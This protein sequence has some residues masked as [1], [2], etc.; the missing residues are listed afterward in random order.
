MIRILKGLCLSIALLSC[1][2]FAS[3]TPA[4]ETATIRGIVADPSGAVIPGATV[5][6]VSHNRVQRTKSGPEGR[7]SFSSLAPGTYSVTVAAKGF[8]PFTTP[9]V[10]LAAGAAKDLKVS[11]AIAVEQE[12]VTVDDHS[13]SVGL[14]PDQNS[15]AMVIKGSDLDALSDD[16]D[17]LQNELQ[18]LAGPAAGPSGGQIY[19]DGFEGGQIPPKSSILEIRVNQNPFSAEFDRIGYGRIEIITKPGTQKL[20]GNFGGFGTASPLNT[21]NP[22]V[23]QP[24]FYDFYSAMGNV[25]G[26]LSKKAAYF[27]NV[28]DMQRQTQSIVNA[29]NPNNPSTNIVEFFPTP[30]SIFEISPRIDFQLGIHNITIRDGFFRSVASNNGVG[31]LNLPSQ[32]VSS[33]DKENSVQIG[34]TVVINEHLVNETHFQWRR[35]RNDQTAVKFTPAVTVQGS[36]TK[37]GSSTGVVQDHEDNFE[38]QNYSTATA[39]KHILRFGTRLRAERDTNFSESGTNGAYSFSTL[40]AYQAQTPT[41]YSQTVV[42]NPIARA[43]LFDA[44]LFLQ[45]DWHP[46]KNLVAGLGL[47]YEGQN[48]IRDHAD[49]GPRV[50]FAWSP[51]YQGKGAAKT[52]VR[53]GYGWFYNRFTVP[54]SFQSSGTPYIIQTIHDNGINQKS[55]TVKAP[56]FFNP[57]APQTEQ[58]LQSLGTTVPTY[59]TVDPHFHAALDMQGGVGVDRQITKALTGNITYLFTQG[60]HQYLMDNVTAPD[61]DPSTYTVNGTTPAAYNYQFQSGGFYRQQEL[62]VTAKAHF[63][64]LSFDSNYTLNYANSDTQG[65]NSVPM[66][67]QHPGLD[68]GRASFGI[69]HRIFLLLTYTAPGG[70]I[71]APLLAA[72]SGTPYNI[73][74]GT[75]LTQ[76]NQFNARP[77]Y[78]ICGQ[79]GLVS[80]PFGCLDSNPVGKNEKIVP[81]NLGTGP[82]NFVLHLRASKTIGIGPHIKQE[83]D[84]AGQ[85]VNNSVNGRGLSGNGGGVKIDEKVPR[86]YNITFVAIA[87]NVFNVVNWAPPNGVMDSRLFGQTQSL[88]SGPYSGPTPGNRT[89]LFFTNFTF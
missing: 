8:A 34:D 31:D 12:H 42:S 27:F 43:I 18:A 65:A 14:S 29:L 52:V 59:H 48:R 21:G 80:T 73:T 4:Q 81:Y 68:Y 33:N 36:F 74:T 84:L 72:Q 49:W 39:G 20:K 24:P 11:L 2:F 51:G 70:V 87:L 60:V 35:I 79:P 10:V 67:P 85:N 62:L 89:I 57:N 64:H 13:E 66:D 17:E 44:A 55:Y 25:S 19:I 38:L 46:R 71:F 45:D 53:G 23:G 54:N 76:N 7:F 82:A 83:G 5:S 9:D 69:R 86:K 58:T 75:D 50:A 77:A 47:R 61:F 30:S 56:P 78:G 15:S 41:L 26:P 3:P 32:A 6:L 1:L 22:I 28:F 40:A 63:K 88:A 16:P 37:G